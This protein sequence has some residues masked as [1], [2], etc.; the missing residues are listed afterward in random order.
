MTTLFER[1]NAIIFPFE[2]VSEKQRS[3]IG[4][5]VINHF[6]EA[7]PDHERLSKSTFT[8]E[9]GTFH[10]TVYPDWFAPEMDA[11]IAQELAPKPPKP[12]QKVA[13]IKDEPPS[14]ERKPR[15]RIP[16]K[17]Q[18]AFSIKKAS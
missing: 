4:K 6:K 12:I 9:K 16:S 3:Q 14:I 10:V 11:I 1:I 2:T 5:K 7:H 15:K 17:S 8:N 18:P 13:E